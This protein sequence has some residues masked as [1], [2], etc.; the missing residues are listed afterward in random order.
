MSQRICILGNAGSGKTTMARTLAAEHALAHLDLDAVAWA[1]PGVRLPLDESARAIV[2]FLERHEAWVAEGSYASLAA[3][4]LPWCSE[5][6]F[7]DPGTEACVRQCEGRAWEPEKFAS[8]AEQEAA[9]GFL[10]DWVRRYDTRDDEYGRAAH[11]ALFDAF[12]GPKAVLGR[13]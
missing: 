4:V 11:Q 3:V 10:L 2:A 8:E 7:L 12:D 13:L 5:L 9:L 1:E 6:R